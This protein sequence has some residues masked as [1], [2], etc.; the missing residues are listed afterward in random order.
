M[1]DPIADMLARIRNAAVAH[2]DV[3]KIPASKIKFAIGEIFKREG[4]SADVVVF[5]E[6]EVNDLSTFEHPHQYSRGFR[7]VLVNGQVV[8]ENG[9]HLGTRSG[10]ALR[11]IGYSL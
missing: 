3:T 7:Y 2:H 5:D 8:V 6:K 4:Y 10:K 11:G 1:T 9:Q